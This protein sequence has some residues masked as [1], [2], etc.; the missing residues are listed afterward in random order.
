MPQGRTR[1]ARTMEVVRTAWVTPRMRRVVFTGSDL[2][3]VP[4]LP[5]TDSYVKL[6]FGEVTRTYTIRSFDRRTNEL[7]IDFVVHGDEGLAGPWARAAQ[8]G[9]RLSCYGPG[10]D[11]APDLV[12]P[13][14]LLA[15]DEAAIPAI[16]T[17]LER[18][19]ARPGVSVF[20]E[21]TD[22]ADRPALPDHPSAQITW[23]E[24]GDRP[25]GEALV[26]AVREAGPPPPGSQV[27]VHG[28]ATI[29]KDLRRWFFVE[30]ELDRRQVSISGY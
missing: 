6:I 29:V 30:H 12:A 1:T 9:D 27:F 22:A 24:R 25:Y 26:E 19:G 4:E 20:V 21:V 13:A 16:A 15:G 7:A 23:V 3:V 18:L 8:P 17:A 2:A 14:H 5:H 28:N 11:F 10:G